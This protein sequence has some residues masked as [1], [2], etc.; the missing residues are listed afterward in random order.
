[1]SK[2]RWKA[3]FLWNRRGLSPADYILEKRKNY[4]QP[5][6]Y[7]EKR[8][9]VFSGTQAPLSASHSPTLDY[10]TLLCDYQIQVDCPK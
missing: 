1:M 10:C 2:G 3:F 5:E 4:V 6:F 7:K 8:L 9:D